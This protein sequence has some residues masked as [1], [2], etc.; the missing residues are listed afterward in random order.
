MYTSKQ[1]LTDAIGAEPLLQLCDDTQIGDWTTGDADG[2]TATNRLNSAITQA[3]RLIDS[4]AKAHFSVPFETTPPLVAEMA[5]ALTLYYLYRR[6]RAAFGM[7][8]DVKDEH[9]DTMKRLERLNQGKLDLGVEPTPT[10]SD[11]SVA[12]SDGPDQLFTSTTLSKFS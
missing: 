6:R 3:G 11:L 5:V 9:K 10:K 12:Q 2:R 8:E 1:E 4:Y 7:P